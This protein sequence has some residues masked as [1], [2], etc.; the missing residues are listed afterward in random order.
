RLRRV[1]PFHVGARPS[2]GEGAAA[3]EEMGENARDRPSA[4]RV[5]DLTGLRL[6]T[7]RLMSNQRR[8]GI[9]AMEGST[10]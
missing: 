4:G 2:R 8:W 3:G 10:R 9:R 1:G 6:R 7:S 5:L